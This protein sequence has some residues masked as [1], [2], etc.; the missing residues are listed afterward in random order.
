M[1]RFRNALPLVAALV[2]LALPAAAAAS[3]RDVIRDCAQDG[4]LDGRYS[5][6]ELREAESDLPTDIDEYSD[7]RETIRRA[8]LQSSRE[9]RGRDAGAAG[10]PGGGGGPARAGVATPPPDAADLDAL[11]KATAAADPG[12][13]PEV[14]VGDRRV[15]PGAA[16]LFG[17]A[18]RVNRLP[19]PILLALVSIGALT[20]GGGYLTLRRRVPLAVRRVA[21]RF[22]RH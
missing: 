6:K 12:D 14:A 2:A 13:A 21:L 5:D 7:C 1:G 19:L 3:G 22:R 16:G 18:T 4:R 15:A 9:R 8:R 17:A 10:A 11:R 20:A